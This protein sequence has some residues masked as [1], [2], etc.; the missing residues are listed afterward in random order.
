[1]RNMPEAH[2]YRV[3]GQLHCPDIDR[4]SDD[5]VVVSVS[6]VFSAS[7]ARYTLNKMIK[8][9]SQDLGRAL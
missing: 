7:A 2:R 6:A 8:D 3:G 9:L 5:W 4:H 1:M